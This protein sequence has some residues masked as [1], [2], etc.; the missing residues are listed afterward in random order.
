LGFRPRLPVTA[1][2]YSCQHCRPTV[3]RPP[4]VSGGTGGSS[5]LGGLRLGVGV[6]L[7]T[8]R[9]RRARSRERTRPPPGGEGSVVGL[10][11]RICGRPLPHR[12]AVTH[13]LEDGCF[14]A[15]LA[16]I[17][18]RRAG[19]TSRYGTVRGV[20]AYASL[21]CAYARGLLAITRP[22]LGNLTHRWGLSP[23]RP[24]TLSRGAR[25]PTAAPFGRY[26]RASVYTQVYVRV[27]TCTYARTPRIRGSLTGRGRDRS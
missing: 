10:D 7:P 8:G 16:V 19:C 14:Q 24:P 25:T 15:H 22:T 11:P 12:C 17:C 27:R 5:G 6:L 3:G 13:C 4:R 20:R 26:A 9:S 21:G 2:C 1:S 23:S 18:P